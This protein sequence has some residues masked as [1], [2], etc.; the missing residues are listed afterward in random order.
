MHRKFSSCGMEIFFLRHGN[1]FLCTENFLPVHR[2]FSSC[3]QKIF[4]AQKIIFLCTE[5]FLP[6]HRNFSSCGMEI[7]F[8]EP[9]NSCPSLSG[10]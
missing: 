4:C 7:F 5:T 10:S 2:K 9:G 1:F 6:V 8:Q 3:A